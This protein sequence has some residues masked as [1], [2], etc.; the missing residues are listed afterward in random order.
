MKNLFLIIAAFLITTNA[1][2]YT[3]IA[4]GTINTDSTWTLA[5]SPY[6]ILDDLTIGTNVILHIEAD[7]VIKFKYE[8]SS[9]NNWNREVCLTVNGILDV[10]GTQ[11]NP[12]VFT[13]ELDDSY[14]GDS[15]GDGNTTVPAKGNW[16]YIRFNTPSA[17]TNIFEHAIVNYGGRRQTGYSSYNNYALWI[18]GT[19]TSVT[20]QNC[21]FSDASDQTIRIDN[22]IADILNNTISNST[23]W[24]IYGNSSTGNITANSIDNCGNGI[25]YKASTILGDIA[26]NVI[27]NCSGTG[28]YY[29]G[30]GNSSAIISGNDISNSNN[31]IVTDNTGSIDIQNNQI[32]DNSGY[33]FSQYN[34]SFPNYSGNVVTNNNNNSIAIKGSMSNTGY[35][36]TGTWINVQGLNMPYT[37]IDDLTIGHNMTLI[38]PQS[39]V[40]KFKY[41]QSSY[42]NWNREVCLTVNG[43]L[44]VQGTQ[45]NPVVFT[46][47]R[48]DSYGGDSNGDGN[49]T[50]PAKGN[51][52]YIRFNTPSAI[53]NIFEHAIVNYG[54]RRQTGYS[55]YNNYALWIYG[56]TTS[57]TVQNCEFSDASDQ[58]IRIDNTIADILNNTISNSTSWAIYGNSS[59]GNIT[60]NSID[61]CGNGIYYKAS[62]ILGD[63]ANNVVNN[64]SGTGIYYLGN[65]NSSAII[66][67]N[68]ISNS[69]NAI[70]TDNTGNISV[71]NNQI[72]NCNDYALSQYNYSFPNYSGNLFTNNSKNSIAIKGNIDNIGFPITGTWENVQGINMPYTIIDDLTIGH[73]M[74]LII[75]QSIVVKF[76]YEQSSYNNWNREVC[77]TVNGILDVQGTQTNP[78]VFTS[79]RDDSYGGDSNGDGNTTVPAKGNW[80]YIRFNT[81]SAIT[82]IF[83][84]AIV[85][86]GGRR[87]TGY[88]SYNNYA[89]WIYGTTTSVTVQNCEFSDASDQTI[90]IDN[91][92]ADI[93]NNTISNSTSWAIYGNSS[94]GNITANSIDN[95]G[96]GI[97]Y[98]ASTIL[99][100]IANNVV[101][102]CSGTG[103]YY[104]GNGNSSAIIS[105][106]DISNSNNAIVTDNTG[107]I[108]V[109]NNQISNCNDYALS[110]YNY[111]FPNYSGNLFTNNSKNS[112]AIKGNIDN[113]GFPIT[114]TWEN[115]QGINMPYTIIDDLTIGHNM[116]LIIP[117]SIVVKFKYEQS[118]YNNWN[119]EVCLTVNGILDVQGTQTNPVV[120][121]SERDDS[122][123][124]DSNGDGNTTVPAKGNWGY[125]R[126]NTPSAITNIF[127][128]AIVNY[129][130]RRQTG[131]SSYN[132]YTLFIDG[133]N[134]NVTVQNCTFNEVYGDGIYANNVS[135]QGYLFINNLTIR[136]CNGRGIYLL[137]INTSEVL[138]KKVISL[139]SNYG[140]YLNNTNAIIDAC[141]FSD[142][143]IGL[144]VYGN[145]NPLI[146]NSYFLNNSDIG[147]W[148][149]GNN[150]NP[151]P[152]INDNNFTNNTNY[153]IKLEAYNNPDTTIINAQNNWY[154]ATDSATI[155]TKL[156]HNPDNST[157]ATLNWIPF[158]LEENVVPESIYCPADINMDASVDGVD[159]ALL[160]FS[161]GQDTVSHYYN[162]DADI[163][164]SGRVDGFDL[165]IL[166]L[167]FG[168]VGSCILGKE[169][170]TGRTL[171]LITLE[172]DAEKTQIG[173]TMTVWF[174]LS[175]FDQPYAFITNI[176]INNSML[177]YCNAEKG[178]LL[179]ENGQHQ[180]TLMQTGNEYFRM[181]GITRMDIE[182]ELTE[183]SGCLMKMKFIKKSEEIDLQNALLLSD[184]LLI[185]GFGEWAETIDI[186]YGDPTG[187]NNFGA[188]EEFVRLFPNPFD[189]QLSVAFTLMENSYVKLYLVNAHGQICNVLSEQACQKEDYQ[190]TFE[191][192][193]LP[194]GFYLFVMELDGQRVTKK[195]IHQ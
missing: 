78:V 182:N 117:Q 168:H 36:I 98:K 132:N 153:N 148:A 47:E 107:N 156:Y 142:N 139:G 8:Q 6:H 133:A 145:S 61:N 35:P 113:I 100:D 65:G 1:N 31:A 10:Q 34:Y 16:G 114:G 94:T 50:V 92:I 165:A 26:N 76:K 67:G 81:P 144:Y 106:N 121:T 29:L 108:S 140:M 22:T 101:N 151:M 96:N 57:V 4:G 75:P 38:I 49:T 56:T 137:N 85:N 187:I 155:A 186:Q 162:I 184:A 128:H 55:S 152:I 157:S 13:S 104:L 102:N 70:V 149:K 105:G 169:P 42:N 20:V 192:S 45:T 84:H 46:S 86:Y 118:S 79:E 63:I 2:A 103:I 190:W 12:V 21:E 183:S 143:N 23:S 3:S 177:G 82:N 27:N 66:S 122:Y 41:E 185:N 119:R 127:E 170:F 69:N 19:T 51:W 163:D 112:I 173:D 33:P 17:I 129:G 72:S 181:L 171:P 178:G 60:A 95:C 99:G 93:L 154:N 158:A 111:S 126:F 15:N 110:Q 123:G 64:C 188:E 37:I 150:S 159:L 193:E 7:V 14:G 115:V 32:S 40:V 91:T 146:I 175:E 130:G 83:E 164:L 194:K 30:N 166:G 44:D 160:G 71:Q 77:L 48:D 25:Y 88:S 136:N 141:G 174:N 147:L 39:I 120:F 97:Y 54:G 28:I 74:T 179:S 134:T 18:Y 161:F 73:N 87:Q 80:G 172:S 167:N 11:T 135:E 189:H 9:Y 5:G 24:A 124:G 138:I 180:T 43:I 53:T 195:I 68:D 125:I 62:T 89:L 131:Y 109:Q 59:T 52:G 58:T 116:T 176:N 90:R 191:T